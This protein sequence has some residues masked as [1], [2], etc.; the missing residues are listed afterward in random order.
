MFN[1]SDKTTPLTRRALIRGATAS[2]LI[3]MNPASTLA[4]PDRIKRI[5]DPVAF[6]I[7]RWADDPHSYGSYSYLAKGST[8]KDRRRLAAPVGQTLFFAGEA[9]HSAHPAT[10]HGALLSGQLA[11]Q[12]CTQTSRRNIAIVGAGVAGL[13]AAQSLVRS[14]H[15]VTV[16][17]SRNRIGGR[18][19]TDRSL[20]VALDLG[21]SWIHGVNGNPL[22][23]ISDQLNLRRV[24][25]R[26]SFVARDHTGAILRDRDMSTDFLR[27]LEIEHEYATDFRNLSRRAQSEG[28]EYSGADVIFPDG[29]DGILRG[30]GSKA[31]VLMGRP[32]SRI[33]HGPNSAT[34]RSGNQS[35]TFDAI[36]VTVPLGVLKSGKLIFS[37]DLPQR[38]SNAIDRLGMGVLDK[39][40][41]KFPKPFWD[42]TQWIGYS[43]PNRARFAQWFNIHLSVGSPILLAFNAGSAARSIAQQTDNQ[44]VDDA[45]SALT[46][47]YG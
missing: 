13:A 23:S 27:I 6:R 20:G 2:G 43:G 31:K 3:L 37:P 21:A 25:T 1:K 15:T 38:K 28:D 10:V 26:D 44:I 8:P 22:T 42:Q 40:Y 7:T 29:Y 12:Q 35:R 16:F 34:I 36:I 5:P 19:V 46:A 47:M 4:T 39:V 33:N 24:V 18:V 45:M 32:V 9:T 30:L 41:L 11:A 14:G 17:E